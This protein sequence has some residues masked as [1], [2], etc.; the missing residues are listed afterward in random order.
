MILRNPAE[1]AFSQYLHALGMGAIH[2]T[3]REQI[4]DSLRARTSTF[5]ILYPFLEFGLYYD[6]V[7]RYLERFPRER[8]R[9]YLYEDY[10]NEPRRML[11][12]I[13]RLLSVDFTFVPNM[14][15]KRLEARVPRSPL[16]GRLLRKCGFLG[17]SRLGALRPFFFKNRAALAMEP[18]DRAYLVDFY[19]DDIRKLSRLLSRDLNAWLQ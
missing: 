14:T 10:Q 18:A 1:R 12:D 19:R 5:G 2:K 16:I 8:V 11:E 3:F 6:Q 9:I 7:K 15:Q 17:G 4:N 13:F